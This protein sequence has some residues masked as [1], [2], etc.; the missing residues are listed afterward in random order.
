MRRHGDE[1]ETDNVGGNWT[2]LT[3]AT[4]SSVAALRK[5]HC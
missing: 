1:E 2:V 3:L 4:I 5:R